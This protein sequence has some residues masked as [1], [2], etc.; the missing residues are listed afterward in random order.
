MPIHRGKD[1]IGD[2]FQYGETG[3]KYHYNRYRH[4][5]KILAYQNALM[6]SK[7]IHA[8]QNRRKKK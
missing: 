8:S 5:S 1:G 6:Q 2:Y 4:I 7:A 3:V